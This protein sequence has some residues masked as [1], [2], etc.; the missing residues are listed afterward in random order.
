MLAIIGC[1]VA[2][3]LGGDAG[4]GHLLMAKM[5]AYETDSL[6]AVLMLL[7]WLGC[8]FHFAVRALRRVVVPWHGSAG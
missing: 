2:Q 3:M 1:V 6:F 8:C 7:A 5:N 4:L